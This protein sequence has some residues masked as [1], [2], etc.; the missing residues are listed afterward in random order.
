MFEGNGVLAIRQTG[1]QRSGE[2]LALFQHFT[3]AADVQREYVPALAVAVGIL[4]EDVTGDAM[5][6]LSKSAISGLAPVTT[7]SDMVVK[8]VMFMIGIIP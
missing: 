3:F 5:R 1:G 4:S 6:G 7:I 8:C 2:L